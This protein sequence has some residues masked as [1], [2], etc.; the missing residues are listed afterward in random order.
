MQSRQV[1]HKL[2]N[3]LAAVLHLYLAQHRRVLA[4]LIQWAAGKVDDQAQSA[5]LVAAANAH[6]ITPKV[7]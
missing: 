7:S 6:A 1:L 5:F 3:Q 2:L 4:Q